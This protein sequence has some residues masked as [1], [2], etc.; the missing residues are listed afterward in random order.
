MN[1]ASG[2]VLGLA[3]LTSSPTL[4]QGA[5][6]ELPLDTVLTRYLIS[7]V[8]VWA[9]ISALGFLVGSAPA[10]IPDPTP[11][12]ATDDGSDHDP[13]SLQSP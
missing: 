13:A 10:R 4:M 5:H 6:G 2:T 1:I 11:V 8:L 3:A 7:V 9:A 12:P